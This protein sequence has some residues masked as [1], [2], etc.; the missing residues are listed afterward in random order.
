M[1]PQLLWQ[2]NKS[3]AQNKSHL[4][5]KHEG[6]EIEVKLDDISHFQSIGN[7]VKIFFN[8]QNK[9]ILVYGSLKNIL[10]NTDSEKFIQTHKSYVINMDCIKK[11][12]KDQVVLLND[13]QIPLGRKFELL[14]NKMRSGK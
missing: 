6:V 13:I 2:A 11:R 8:A 14:V 7:Y 1:L 9:P 12:E 3:K 4:T 10:S 5:L